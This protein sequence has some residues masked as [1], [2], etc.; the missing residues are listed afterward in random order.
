MVPH[1]VKDGGGPLPPGT[2]KRQGG[3]GTHPPEDLEI[4]PTA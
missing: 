2:L 3:G 1:Y 4:N